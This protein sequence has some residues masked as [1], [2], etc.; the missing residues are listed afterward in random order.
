[1]AKLNSIIA[2]YNITAN[3]TYVFLTTKSKKRGYWT[4]TLFVDSLNVSHQ[5]EVKYKDLLNFEGDIDYIKLFETFLEQKT[6]F[7]NDDLANLTY[8]AKYA[9]PHKDRWQPFQITKSYSGVPN[10]LK[11]A[12]YSV[13]NMATDSAFAKEYYHLMKD[14]QSA[15]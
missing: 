8:Q 7:D 12:T 5:W 10:D 2:C 6:F 1:M 15:Y 11:A 14:W 4:L 3:S 9:R 13:W